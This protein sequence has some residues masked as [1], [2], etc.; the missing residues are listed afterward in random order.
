M[1]VFEDEYSASL[2]TVIFSAC[3]GTGLLAGGGLMVCACVCI[4]CFVGE[5]SVSFVHFVF[6]WVFLCAR[7][8]FIECLVF[9]WTVIL[10]FVLV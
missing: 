1:I 5:E 7:V 2:W 4:V 9:W 8:V 6:L 10:V 3:V